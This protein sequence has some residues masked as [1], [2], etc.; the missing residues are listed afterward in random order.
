MHVRMKI[1]IAL[2]CGGDLKT[3]FVL[4]RDDSRNCDNLNG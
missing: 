3:L 4:W 2:L 1:D